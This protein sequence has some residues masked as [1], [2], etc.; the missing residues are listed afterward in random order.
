MTITAPTVAPMAPTAK[1]M[2]RNSLNAA[3]W[4][5]LG[6]SD[7]EGKSVMTVDL[8]GPGG[9][10]SR[11]ESPLLGDNLSPA[12]GRYILMPESLGRHNNTIGLTNDFRVLSPRKISGILRLTPRMTPHISAAPTANGAYR[13]RRA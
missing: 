2:G 6:R 11:L 7:G 4:A 1:N 5:V 10:G 3:E 12:A 8:C 9:S 13:K